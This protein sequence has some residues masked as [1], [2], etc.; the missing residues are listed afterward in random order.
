MQTLRW[1]VAA[2]VFVALLFLSLENSDPATLKFFS[3]ATWSAPLVV[4]V[5][6]AFASGAAVGLLAG[7]L[8]TARLKRELQR[9]RRE[10][11]AAE[12]PVLPP[13]D[14]TPPDAEPAPG[15]APQRGDWRTGGR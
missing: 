10:T 4:I 13:L 6:I 3:F 12:R 9:M 8:R 15:T 7:A 5:F 1:I 2:A 14:A 11:R